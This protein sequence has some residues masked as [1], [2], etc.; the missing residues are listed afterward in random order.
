M[1]KEDLGKHFWIMHCVSEAKITKAD[2]EILE[3]RIKNNEYDTEARA[4]LLGYYS[5]RTRSAKA[6]SIKR[7]QHILWVLEYAPDCGLGLTPFLYISKSRHPDD[8][9]KAKKLLLEQCENFKHDPA[10]LTD[11]SAVM[12]FEEPEIAITLLRQA[13]R[14]LPQGSTTAF[15]LASTLYAL[16]RQNNDLKALNES[17][18]FMQKALAANEPTPLFD[19][20][21]WLVIFAFDAGQHALASTTC[22]QMLKDN[23]T[24][25]QSVHVAHIVLGRIALKDKDMPKAIEHLKLAGKVGSSPRLSSYGPMMLLAQSLLEAGQK[26]AVIEYLTDCKSFWDVGKRNLTKWIGQI[27]AG[28]QP[29]LVGDDE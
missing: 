12:R 7:N 24:N 5:R 13:H 8:F 2:A 14:A 11:L 28:E 21:T 25:N 17:V 22:S 1:N 4:L 3:E 6:D 19:Q 10:V 26:D 20:R 29:I 23:A 18:E 15:I 16:G 27:Q 9:E